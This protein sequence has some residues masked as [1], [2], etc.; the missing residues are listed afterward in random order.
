MS[1]NSAAF[2]EM[3]AYCDGVSSELDA[4]YAEQAKEAARKSAAGM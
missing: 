1:E 3:V 4:F 2:Q